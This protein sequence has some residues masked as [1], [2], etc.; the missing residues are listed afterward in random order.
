VTLDRLLNSFRM[1]VP[2]QKDQATDRG[3]EFSA[4]PLNL[5]GQDGARD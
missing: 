3:L 1:G 4:P 5:W 2:H